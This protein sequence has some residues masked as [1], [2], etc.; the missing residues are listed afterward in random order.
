MSEMKSGMSMEWQVLG[1]V[2][3]TH[4][5]TWMECERFL[6]CANHKLPHPVALLRKTYFTKLKP[7]N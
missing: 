1:E 7:I 2:S 3:L 6:D 4:V 5:H